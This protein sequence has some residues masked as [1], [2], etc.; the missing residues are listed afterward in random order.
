MENVEDSQDSVESK[1]RLPD[2]DSISSKASSR[3]K[4]R[5][6]RT[7]RHLD[8][9]LIDA[10]GIVVH[11]ANDAMDDTLM[12]ALK[13]PVGS[14]VALHSRWPATPQFVPQLPA[15]TSAADGF[16]YLAQHKQALWG[17]MRDEC[18]IIGHS[19][20]ILRRVY[21][22]ALRASDGLPNESQDTRQTQTIQNIEVINMTVTNA[23]E[24]MLAVMEVTLRIPSEI[25]SN[26]YKRKICSDYDTVLNAASL[27]G[28]PRNVV[29]NTRK[30]MFQLFS[31]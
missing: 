2:N 3:R 18:A 20:L 8:P 24:R 26:P 15:E 13:Q 14:K 19:E 10:R 22:E 1:S 12:K 28:V 31:E 17:V 30:R 5:K 29:E 4:W 16:H 27:A 25:S 7:E 21:N 23:L 9:A 11:L 6:G